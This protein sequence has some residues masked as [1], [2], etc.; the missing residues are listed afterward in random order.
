MLQGE[1]YGRRRL[2]GMCIARRVALPMLASG[3]LVLGGCGMF[4]T[5]SKE[6]AMNEVAWR[7]AQEAIEIDVQAQPGLN[8]WGGQPHTLL[9]VVAQAHEPGELEPYVIDPNKLAALLLAETAPSPLLGLN[10]F[11]VEPGS[12]RSYRLARVDQARYV[13]VVLGYQ[14]LDPA[15][16]ARLYKIGAEL[17]YEGLIFRVYRAQPQ[18]LTIRLKLGDDG[19]LDSLATTQG[20]SPSISPASGMIIPSGLGT[21]VSTETMQ[22]PDDMAPSPATFMNTSTQDQP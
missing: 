3:L 7:Y 11:F 13:A 14:H 2:A 8:R 22:A 10:K 17:D 16:S 4:K 19:V 18:P 21:P 15:R 9:M 6:E 20:P 12:E 1:G 5:K